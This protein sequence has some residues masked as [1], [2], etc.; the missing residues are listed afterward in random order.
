MKECEETRANQHPD[1]TLIHLFMRTTD[2]I[3]NRWTKGSRP[4]QRL[5][6]SP[7]LRKTLRAMISVPMVPRITTVML[8]SGISTAATKGDTRP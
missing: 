1:P 6:S 8:L 5:A 4:I 7:Y 2:L 3:K